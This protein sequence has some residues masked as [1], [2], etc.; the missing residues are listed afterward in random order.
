VTTPYYRHERHTARARADAVMLVEIAH[1]LRQ[2]AGYDQQIDARRG[3]VSS[4]KP[5]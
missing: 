2:V 3:D 5:P 4:S 1:V